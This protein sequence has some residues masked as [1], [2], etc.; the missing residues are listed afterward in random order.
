V[1]ADF[2]HWTLVMERL[3]HQE[4]PPSSEPP[5]PAALRQRVIDWVKAGAPTNCARTQAI[6]ARC[7]PAA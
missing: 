7:S 4:M 6:Q 5:P 2:P 1:L 3:A